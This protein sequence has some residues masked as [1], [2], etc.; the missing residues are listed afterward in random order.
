MVS[1]Y[2]YTFGDGSTMADRNG[3]KTL[4]EAKSWAKNHNKGT[5]IKSRKVISVTASKP[6]VRKRIVKRKT[7]RRTN[8]FPT[9]RF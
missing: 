3:Y 2:I 1:K 5:K 6:T 9:F 8:S 7:Q 4:A